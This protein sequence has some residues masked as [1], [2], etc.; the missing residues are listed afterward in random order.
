MEAP[1]DIA[2]GFAVI[3][4]GL[5]LVGAAQPAA[6]EGNLARRPRRGWRVPDRAALALVEIDAPARCGSALRPFLTLIPCAAPISAVSE[7][8]LVA[9]ADAR[10]GAEV[11]RPI[12]FSV[13][14]SIC[15][16]RFAQPDGAPADRQTDEP[17]NTPPQ[18]SND[19]T[20]QRSNDTP[21]SSWL[22]LATASRTVRIAVAEDST[23]SVR[24]ESAV[25]WTGPRPSGFCPKL[26]LGDL[27]LPRGPKNLL[28]RFHGPCIVWLEGSGKRAEVPANP[29]MRRAV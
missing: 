22:V 1:V 24:P 14:G 16:T 26:G 8:I 20:I 21:T 28:L 27:L 2:N 10:S 5:W 9:P 4:P 11:L 19:P 6:Y 29:F 13:K 17:G 7:K 12:P 3:G 18:R 23:L 15:I 25:A